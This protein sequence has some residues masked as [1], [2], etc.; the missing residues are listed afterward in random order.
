LEWTR[1]DFDKD[2]KC[3]RGASFDYVAYGLRAAGRVG[4]GPGGRC[5][6]LGFRCVRE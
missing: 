5:G 4:Y 1:S 2:R 6:L 3:V